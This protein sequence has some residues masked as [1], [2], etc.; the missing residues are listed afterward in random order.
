MNAAIHGKDDMEIMLSIGEE[1]PEG[2]SVLATVRMNPERSLLDALET[3]RVKGT[4]P[5]LY[6][7][8]CH[9][10]SCGTCGALV[11]GKPKLLCV[12]KLSELG[13]GV[14]RIEALPGATIIGDIA[15]HPGKFLSGLPDTGYL[16][17]E[18]GGCE[19][20]EDCIECGICA[21]AC[22]VKKDFIGP[23]ALAAVES[24]LVRHS[25]DPEEM[26]AIAGRPTG[27]A[28]CEKKFECSKACPRGVA[29]GRKIESLRRRLQARETGQ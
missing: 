17:I 25:G 7:H 21:A 24:E 5:L 11:D 2:S 8:S 19:R 3:L 13:E 27:T 26:L 22:P 23:A 10:G 4:R 1:G 15:V 6:R 9:H 18:E 12:T 28:A 29:P 14:H 20:L 16:R